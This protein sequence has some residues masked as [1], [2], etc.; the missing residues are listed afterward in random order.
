MEG[1]NHVVATSLLAL[2]SFLKNK[3]S[4]LLTNK[5]SNVSLIYSKST[6]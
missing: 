2:N 1:A 6:M 4:P 3:K 5:K